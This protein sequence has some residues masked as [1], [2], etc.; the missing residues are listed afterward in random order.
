MESRFFSLTLSALDHRYDRAQIFS[1]AADCIYGN[2]GVSAQI[3]NLRRTSGTSNSE[4][5]D[6]HATLSPPVKHVLNPGDTLFV[7]AFL[8]IP[9]YKVS[10]TALLLKLASKKSVSPMVWGFDKVTG[11]AQMCASA[12]LSA[13]RTQMMLRTLGELEDKRGE[14]QIADAS[15]KMFESSIKH[16]YHFVRWTAVQSAFHADPELG[17]SLLRRLENDPHPHIVSASKKALARLSVG[18]K[19][20]RE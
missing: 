2:V 5:F 20:S 16:P 10:G 3:I 4:I 12:D 9:E 7:K 13:S 14:N 8:D 17:L 18:T 15:I 11:E 6:K 19:E 1:A